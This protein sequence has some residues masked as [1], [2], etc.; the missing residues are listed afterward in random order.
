LSEDEFISLV[1]MPV[2]PRKYNILSN[3]ENNRIRSNR[4]KRMLHGEYE[5]KGLFDIYYDK[6]CNEM[7]ICR[8]GRQ[9]FNEFPVRTTCFNARSFSQ[10]SELAVTTSQVVKPPY[11]G[12]TINQ[13]VCRIANRYMFR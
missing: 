8:S 5:P 9:I 1:A 13:Y 3:P 7:T 10:H 2:N 11:A 6:R 12:I 4:I